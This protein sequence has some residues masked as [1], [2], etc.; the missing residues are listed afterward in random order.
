MKIATWN[1]AAINNNPFEYFIHY[2]HSDAYDKLMLGVEQF[3]TEPGELDVPVASVFTPAMFAE[4]QAAMEKQG[5]KGLAEVEAYWNED[6][7][8]RKIVSGFMKDKSL[9]AKRLMSMPDRV[10][11]TINTVDAG[12]A[13]RPTVISCYAQDMV[14]ATAWWRAWMRFMFETPV[15]VE[16]KKGPTTCSPCGLMVPIKKEKYPAIT[17]AEEAISIPLQALCLAVFDATLLH[18]VNA[19]QPS[20]EWQ[21]LKQQVIGAL[22]AKKDERTL[23]ILEH[24][25]ADAD[26]I[27]IQEAAT[28]LSPALRSHPHVGG[29]YHVCDPKLPSAAG[30][31]SLVLL[32]RSRFKPET[33]V[34]VTEQVMAS[35]DKAVP[36][37]N[38]DLIVITADDVEGKQLMLASFHG[39]TDGLATRP[40]FAALHELAC[41]MPERALL[42]GIDA[43]CYAS[44]NGAKQLGVAEWAADFEARGYTSCWGSE[45]PAYAGN[46]TTFNAR[47]FLQPQLQKAAKMESMKQQGDLN[48]KDFILFP[49]AAFAASETTKDNTGGKKYVEGM[50]FP[51]LDFPSDH[52]IVATTLTPC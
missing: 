47:T 37:S 42:L 50:V 39:D 40:M 34:D 12:V 15:T 25:Y 2:P 30:Q 41:T 49:K 11:N 43:N 48:P 20:G 52:G 9:G 5:W 8:P 33:I 28:A 19:V 4:L 1:I 35:F 6:I 29:A 23:A 26:I 10:S 27:C 18:I 51:T 17:D 16:G 14:E 32:S 13:N 38:G 31:N 3:L 36:V 46:F 7:A 24:T 22:Y 44:P 45:Q 21:R